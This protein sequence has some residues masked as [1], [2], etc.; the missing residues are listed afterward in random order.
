MNLSQIFAAIPLILALLKKY[1]QMSH[2]LTEPV[3]IRKA[4]VADATAIAAVQVNS[5][6]TTYRGIVPDSYLNRMDVSMR[7]ERW[8]SILTDQIS[9]TLVYLA[10][11]ASSQV[12]GFA[13]GG[14][15]RGNQ[16]SYTGELYAIYLLQPF[17]KRGIGR[18]LLNAIAE[19]LIQDGHQTMLAWVLKENP[20]CRFYE[21]IGGVSVQEKLIYFDNRPLQEVAYVWKIPIQ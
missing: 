3:N 10:E 12:I 5:W 16:S 14:R 2:N 11:A 19:T 1:F 4:T 20:N 17:Q 6:Q 15:E 13:A 18:L 7:A 9:P 21:E 8:Q